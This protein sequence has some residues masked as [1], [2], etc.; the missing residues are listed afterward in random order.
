[1]CKKVKICILPLRFP[2][3]CTTWQ[4]LPEG[5]EICSVGANTVLVFEGNTIRKVIAPHTHY[6]RLQSQGCQIPSPSTSLRAITTHVLGAK[7][8]NGSCNTEDVR[9]AVIPLLPTTTIAIIG[10]F[11]I[12]DDIIQQHVSRNNLSSF[13]KSWDRWA[14]KVRTSVL[15]SLERK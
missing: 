9:V 14:K 3:T 15:I 5:V 10:N 6:E 11:Q 1:V 2:L 12:A 7:N 13:I 4:S 8:S